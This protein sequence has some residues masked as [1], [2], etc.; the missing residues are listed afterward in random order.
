MKPMPSIPIERLRSS[1]KLVVVIA[2]CIGAA[3]SCSSRYEPEGQFWGNWGPDSVGISSTAAEDDAGTT[4]PTGNNDGVTAGQIGRAVGSS[5][6]GGGG[7][8][9]APSRMAGASS[10]AGA[11]SSA[12]CTLS[13]S[14]TTTAPGGKYR[15]RN[16]GA[17]WIAD[18]SGRFVKSLDVWGNRRLSHVTAWNAATKSAGVAGNK[19]DAVSSATLSA[20]RAHNVT[21]NCE[22]FTGQVVPDDTYRVY[23]E[24]T[25]SNASGPN[26]FESFTKGPLAATVQG[27]ATS[28]DGIVLKFQP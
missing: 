14:V 18:S 11:A 20:H 1:G 6:A 26:H 24:V 5:P 8:I 22:D 25:D 16:V 13:V 3:L 12:D 10:A 21:W 17:I 27:S 9:A 4:E 2:S 28:F 19:V 15:P 7:S 23:F